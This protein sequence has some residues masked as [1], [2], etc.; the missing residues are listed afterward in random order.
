MSK[1][2]LREK[3]ELMLEL[4][5]LEGEMCITTE[6]GMFK[7]INIV[8]KEDSYKSVLVKKWSWKKLRFINIVDNIFVFG[9]VKVFY[10][11]INNINTI[12]SSI[13]EYKTL[14][15]LDVA[16]D[17]YKRCFVDF[18]SIIGSLKTFSI[19]TINC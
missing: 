8:A 10:K 4:K 5:Q 13:K 6:F 7:I 9:S 2:I 11:T 18:Q 16:A 3:S 17:G 12:I 1:K 14:K 15:E 19:I